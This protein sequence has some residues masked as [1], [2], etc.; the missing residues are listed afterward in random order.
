MQGSSSRSPQNAFTPDRWAQIK[1]IY[2]EKVGGHSGWRLIV[3]PS[4]I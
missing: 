1:D 3:E 2:M 4:E